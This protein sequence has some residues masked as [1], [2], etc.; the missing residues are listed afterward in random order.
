MTHPIEIKGG[1]QL[2]ELPSWKTEKLALKCSEILF[3][4]QFINHISSFIP[5]CSSKSN[6]FIFYEKG[7]A[8]TYLERGVSTNLPFSQ[9]IYI[10]LPLRK[11]LK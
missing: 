5:N 6:H 1:R 2:S 4:S 10:F 11:H 9:P 8:K 7:I 3:L